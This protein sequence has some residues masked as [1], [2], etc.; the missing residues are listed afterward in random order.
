MRREASP[1]K[2]FRAHLNVSRVYGNVSN[3][4]TGK[5]TEALNKEPCF[6]FGAAFCNAGDY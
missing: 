2:P 5:V 6:G 3:V 4:I 1:A